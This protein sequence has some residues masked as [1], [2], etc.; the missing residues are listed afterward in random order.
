MR[1]I[2][3]K[4]PVTAFTYNLIELI[5][6]EWYL[7]L[8]H[9]Y[10]IHFHTIVRRFSPRLCTFFVLLISSAFFLIE[11]N[12][13]LSFSFLF[14]PTFLRRML[15]WFP[16]SLLRLHLI[17]LLCW[18][19]WTIYPELT[20]IARVLKQRRRCFA[21]IL[22]STTT[23]EWNGIYERAVVQDEVDVVQDRLDPRTA[24]NDL[25]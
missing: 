1:F 19:T 23:S 10:G 8:L 6:H 15:L 7:S 12:F 3:C 18:T 11:Y 22:Q 4:H 9:R 20:T 2:T 17:N 24:C 13:L 5:N 21:L 25:K 16:P 14:L